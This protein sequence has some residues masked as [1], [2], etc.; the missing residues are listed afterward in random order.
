MTEKHEAPDSAAEDRITGRADLLPEEQVAGS[1]DAR[2][3]AEAILQESD[4]RTDDPEAT[5]AESSQTSTP[6]QRPDA[7]RESSPHPIHDLD[8]EG[9]AAMSQTVGDHILE[10]L[11]DWG[12]EHVFG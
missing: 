7:G 12:V 4:E 11:R 8:Q 2:G 6:D 5:G 3:Q 10:R 9:S 1:D